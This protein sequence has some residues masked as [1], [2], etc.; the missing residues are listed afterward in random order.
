MKSKRS[1]LLPLAS[2]ALGLSAA[3]QSQAAISIT[4][5]FTSPTATTLQGTLSGSQVVVSNTGSGLWDSA[6]SSTHE[7]RVATRVTGNNIWNLANQDSRNMVVTGSGTAAVAGGDSV[8]ITRLDLFSRTSDNRNDFGLSWDRNPTPA[9]AI[10]ETV[11]FSGSFTVALP[12]GRTAGDLNSGTWTQANPIPTW[13]SQFISDPNT[14]AATLTIAAA[15]VPE[16]GS[17]I[18]GALAGLALL[19]R[20]RR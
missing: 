13:T 6:N 7:W 16:P 12:S 10:G 17:A 8:S 19:R 20:R 15:P 18:L 5:T 11:T 14:L 4:L 1:L 9:F 2:L 3:S